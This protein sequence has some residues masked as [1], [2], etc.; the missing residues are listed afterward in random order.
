M[1]RRRTAA[2]WARIV[3]QNFVSCPD[4]EPW[5]EGEVFWMEGRGPTGLRDLVAHTVEVPEDLCDDVMSLVRCPQCGSDVHEWGEVGT[6]WPFEAA[7]RETIEAARRRWDK[8]LNDFASFLEK[9]PGLGAIHPIG[10]RLMKEIGRF[11][12]VDLSEGVWYR[13]RRDEGG[14]TFTTDDLRVPD[15]ATIPIDI[16]R[17]NHPGQAHWYLADDPD[18]AMAEVLKRGEQI[19]WVQ[20][21][22]IASIGRVL[23]LLSFGADDPYPVSDATVHSMPLLAVAMIFGG[24]LNRPADGNWKPE[25]LVPQFVLDAAKHAGFTGIRCQSAKHGGINLVIFDRNSPITAIGIPEKMQLHDPA[26]DPFKVL[27][28]VDFSELL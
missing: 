23:D 27:A 3:E 12:Q 16:G 11:E 2:D 10:K 17:W 19:A 28:P 13:A 9:T 24:Y 25:Y 15:P 5:A 7:H 18:G 6:E 20:K 26:R 8:K 22:Q 1:G 4:C 21:W 14:R